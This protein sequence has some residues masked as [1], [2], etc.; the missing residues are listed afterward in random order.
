MQLSIQA[1]LLNVRNLDRS[2]EFSQRVLGLRLAGR[3]DR[4]AALMIDETK[5]SAQPCGKFL[6]GVGDDVIVGP[7]PLAL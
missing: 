3:D 7:E 4:V 5:C 1:S 6:Q 2:I